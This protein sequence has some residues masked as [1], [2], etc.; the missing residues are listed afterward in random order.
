MHST[1]R[2]NK[3]FLQNI[4]IWINKINL[5]LDVLLDSFLLMLMAKVIIIRYLFVSFKIVSYLY[6]LQ[7]TI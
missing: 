7:I 6:P 5:I 2:V 3:A 1:I 4:Q